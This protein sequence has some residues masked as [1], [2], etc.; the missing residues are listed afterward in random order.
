[1]KLDVDQPIAEATPS[2]AHFDFSK[3]SPRDRYKLLIGTVIPRP[4]AFVTTVD[5]RGVVNA[6]PFSSFN[7]LSSDPAIVAIGVENHPDMRHKDTGHNVRATEEF[8]VN[9]VDDALVAG[10]NVC[11]VL[12][13]PDVDE[14]A[15]AGL[16]RSRAFMLLALASPR[17]RRRSNAAVT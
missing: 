6:A 16:P 11:A 4:I 1:M 14:L 9:I 2:H 15:M 10:M 17:R 13:P 8:T 3:L 5:E 7:C 12:L